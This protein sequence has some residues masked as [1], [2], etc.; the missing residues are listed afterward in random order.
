MKKKNKN[1]T[2]KQ[3]NKQTKKQNK[4]K[5]K[6]KQKQNKTNKKTQNASLHTKN[7]K[8][9]HPGFIYTLLKLYNWECI[10]KNMILMA[11]LRKYIAISHLLN[12]QWRTDLIEFLRTTDQWSSHMVVWQP[13]EGRLNLVESGTKGVVD[14]TGV[15][16]REM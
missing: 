13:P 7:E 2:N 4:N 10:P 11:R 3:T 14:N 12:Q 1:K 5:T 8:K 16:M 9:I 15:N 6:Q